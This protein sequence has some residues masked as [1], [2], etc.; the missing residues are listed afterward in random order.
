M[1]ETLWTKRKKTTRSSR[2]DNSLVIDIVITSNASNVLLVTEMYC[3]NKLALTWVVAQQTGITSQVGDIFIEHLEKNCQ[4][5]IK[6][7][8][9]GRVEN[10]VEK[11]YSSW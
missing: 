11:A 7:S 1:E 4:C 3:E 8:E 10:E 5:S 6:E 2:C 9:Q